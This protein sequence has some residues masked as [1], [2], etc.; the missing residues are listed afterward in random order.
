[1]VKPKPNK[2]GGIETRGPPPLPNRDVFHRV[3]FAYQ[4]AAFLQQLVNTPSI[5]SDVKQSNKRSSKADQK[6]KRKVVLEVGGEGITGSAESG[7]EWGKLARKG[8]KEMKKMA[9][10]TQIEL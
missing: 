9:I 4:S 2:A 8:T 6:K 5:R 7:T 3:N 1:M 10:H